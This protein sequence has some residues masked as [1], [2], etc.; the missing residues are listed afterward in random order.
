MGYE[1][2][3]IGME[4]KY[5]RNYEIRQRNKSDNRTKGDKW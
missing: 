2:F 3:E 5:G 1:N 4:D